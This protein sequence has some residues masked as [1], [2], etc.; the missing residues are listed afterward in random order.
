ME[1]QKNQK[2][3]D[4]IEFI[5]LG[6]K[7]AENNTSKIRTENL[8]K[9]LKGFN[10][11]RVRHLLNNLNSKEGSCYLE[12]GSYR[13][14]SLVCALHK[15]I[16][17]GY[18]VD[19]FKYNPFQNP[20]Y[21]EESWIEIENGLRDNIKRFVEGDKVRIIKGELAHF[22]LKVI[23][24]PI[25]VFYYD[26]YPTK[27]NV[28]DYISRIAPIF[29]KYC[30]VITNHVRTAGS[31]EAIETVFKELEFTVHH[32]V[33]LKSYHPEDYRTWWSGIKIWLIEKEKPLTDK[34]KIDAANAKTAE[35]QKQL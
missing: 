27:G 21:K 6:V 10:S 14:A 35:L 29:A 32:E 25:S 28:Y 31:V 13:G 7:N 19:N 8:T 34:E 16:G 2:V 5:N 9:Y 17:I 20:D 11:V 33:E 4:L 3:S 12:F 22:D 18:T 23:E 1:T 26:A 15:N 30:I 24:H